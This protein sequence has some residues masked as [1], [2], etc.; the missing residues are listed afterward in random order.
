M[1]AQAAQTVFVP[2]HAGCGRPGPGMSILTP[3]ER[4][5]ENESARIH[6]ESQMKVGSASSNGNQDG[7]LLILRILVLVALGSTF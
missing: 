6:T 1:A 3:D 5:R 4:A 7:P 2:R